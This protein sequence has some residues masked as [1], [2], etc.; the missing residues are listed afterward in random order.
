M[1]KEI[2]VLL[3]DDHPTLCFGLKI[4]INNEPD[5]KVT[6]EADNGIRG[7]ELI[8]TLHPDIV[9]LDC[10]LPGKNGI[11][12]AFEIKKSGIKTKILVLSSY[13]ETFYI[14]EMLKAGVAGY[15]LKDEAPLNIINAIRI[16]NNG[17]TWYSQSIASKIAEMVSGA[18]IGVN[19]LS[20]RETEVL[21][22]LASGLSNQDIADKLF[23]SKR[24]IRF[25]LKNIYQKLYMDSRSE[26][27]VWAIQNGFNIKA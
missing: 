25:H 1:D 6:G 10:K 17:K 16:I 3:I 19:D 14:K 22:Y 13:T 23:V 4:L 11:E 21:E 5:M 12:V 24:T 18:N 9:V 20:K 26:V 27:I 7:S 15:L 8:K 2:S